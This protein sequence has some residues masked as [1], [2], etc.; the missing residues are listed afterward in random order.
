MAVQRPQ[1]PARARSRRVGGGGRGHWPQRGRPPSP[2]G[3]VEG[4][5]TI[6]HPQ[7]VH[8]LIILP[9]GLLITVFA[10]SAKRGAR[11]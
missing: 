7:Q 5:G 3:E 2:G 6:V 1:T 9:M 4:K 11:D 10:R 8:A